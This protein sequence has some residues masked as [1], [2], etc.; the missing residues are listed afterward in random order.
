MNWYKKAQLL[1]I[2]E[3]PTGNY[4]EYGHDNYK[5]LNTNYEGYKPNYMWMYINGEIDIEEETKEQSGHHNVQRW[6][7]VRDGYNG[8]YDGKNGI[9]TVVR[10]QIGPAKFRPI[11]KTLQSKL[12]I[13]FPDAIK[14]MVYE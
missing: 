5:R 4:L 8:R 13:A 1:E 10:P 11:P 14:I 7:D 9:I 3:D 6:L 2:E 12:R